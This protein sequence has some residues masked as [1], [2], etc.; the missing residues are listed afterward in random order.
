M[1]G[2]KKP[3][4]DIVDDKYH[5]NDLKFIVPVFYGPM[6]KILL[7]ELR[8]GNK[9]D[10]CTYDYPEQGAIFIVMQ[11]IFQTPIK[12]HYADVTFDN[13]NDPHYWKACYIDSKRKL[14]IACPF[15]GPDFS[16]L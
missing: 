9:V 3:R 13:T 12:R 15:D 4:L 7:A 2:N 10:T 5:E 14:Y 8:A 1:M 11:K 6:R 16:L